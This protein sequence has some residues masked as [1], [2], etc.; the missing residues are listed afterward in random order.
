V[1]PQ[2]LCKVQPER[3]L[4]ERYWVDLERCRTAAEVLDWIMRVAKKS[5]A[6]DETLA[7]LDQT[8]LLDQL[9]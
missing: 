1:A 2:K 6:D 4:D 7:S 5:W 9:K 3:H 8:D